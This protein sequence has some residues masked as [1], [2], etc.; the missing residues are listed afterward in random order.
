M[1]SNTSDGD[2]YTPVDLYRELTSLPVPHAAQFA[3]SEG[4]VAFIYEIAT[5]RRITC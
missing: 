4:I 3:S 2:N 1:N 5:L